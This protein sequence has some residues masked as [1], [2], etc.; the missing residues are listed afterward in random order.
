MGQAS[1]SKTQKE[2]NRRE[3][4]KGYMN[5]SEGKDQKAKYDRERS[6]V[7]KQLPLPQSKRLQPHKSD[8]QYRFADTGD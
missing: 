2:V 5:K 7:C 8:E 6:Q 4:V 1:M 3:Q